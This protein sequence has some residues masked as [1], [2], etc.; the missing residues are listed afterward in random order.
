MPSINRKVLS[1]EIIF[2]LMIV[3]L[4]A[5]LWKVP[6]H[7]L[8]VLNLFYLPI[9]LAGFFLGRYRAG[10]LALFSVVTA[11]AVTVLDLSNFAALASPVIIGLAVTVWGAVLGLTSILVG[12]VSDER[13]EKIDELHQAYVGVVEVLSKYLQSANPRLKHR[14]RRVAELSEA[15]A[16][17]MK[18][19]ERE[20]DDI[21]VAA[22]LQDMESI[23]ITAK[24]I[25]KA[26]DDLGDEDLQAK[27]HTF[28][29]TDLVQSLGSVLRGAFPLVI[30]QRPAD[31]LSAISGTA[32]SADVPLGARVI[33]TVR[34][35][36]SLLQDDWAAAGNSPQQVLRELRE[37]TAAQHHPAVLHALAAVVARH[38]PTAT[39]EEHLDEAVALAVGL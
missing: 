24:V 1:L 33:R 35:Y 28:H 16:R 5:L 18:L 8:V 4:A 26:M 14:S 23:E 10:V 3:A 31:P 25:R 12:T 22:L 21:R 17:Q 7:K 13:T 27:A 9:V 39:I 29:G 38:K 15:V 20:V 6:G 2:T 37:D 36:D 34:A 19:S 32:E 11:S 30:S